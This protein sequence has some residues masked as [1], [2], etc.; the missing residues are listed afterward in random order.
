LKGIISSEFSD[1]RYEVYFKIMGLRVP[2]RD[3]VERS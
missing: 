2:G 3:T 1:E